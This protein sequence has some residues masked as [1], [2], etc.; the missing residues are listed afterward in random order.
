MITYNNSK[1][2]QF[3]FLFYIFDVDNDELLNKNELV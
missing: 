1:R 2:L 3:L